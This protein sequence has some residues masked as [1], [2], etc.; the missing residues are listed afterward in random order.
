MTPKNMIQMVG[1]RKKTQKK[2]TQEQPLERRPFVGGQ[3]TSGSGFGS[4]SAL[5]A[6]RVVRV[7]RGRVVTRR[8]LVQVGR[9]VFANIEVVRVRCM[10]GPPQ[11]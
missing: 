11:G 1:T 10:E 4:M 2:N 5:R 8:P 3:V 6:V 9:W 7:V